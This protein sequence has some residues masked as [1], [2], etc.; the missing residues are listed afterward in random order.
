MP[1]I[2]TT[3]KQ[4]LKSSQDRPLNMVFI[5]NR[6]Q[7]FF[8]LSL[9]FFSSC[10]TLKNGEG[11]IQSGNFTDA[12]QIARAALEKDAQNWHALLLLTESLS[13]QKKYTD[14]EGHGNDLFEGTQKP[15]STIP[16][17]YYGRIFTVYGKI[18]WE[19]G[20]TLLA[21]KG[22]RQARKFDESLVPTEQYI[23]ALENGILYAESKFDFD[24]S[25]QIRNELHALQPNHPETTALKF[26]ASKDAEVSSLERSGRYE[27][28][29]KKYK[30]FLQETPDQ[31]QYQFALG[32][33]QAMMRDRTPQA[34]KTFD[35][36]IQLAQS[37]EKT[38]RTLKVAKQLETLNLPKISSKY[39]EHI[40][41]DNTQTKAQH[42]DLHLILARLYF[43]SNTPAPAHTHLQDYIKL[44]N[45]NATPSSKYY[46]AAAEIAVANNHTKIAVELL[47]QGAQEAPPNW[48]LSRTLADLLSRLSKDKDAEKI[49]QKFVDRASKENASE[50]VKH[51]LDVARWAATRRN[52]ELA[53]FFFEKAVIQKNF[54]SD[55]WLELSQIYAKLGFTSDLRR[56]L[57]SYFKRSSNTKT[58]KYRKVG[59]V[60]QAQ[61]MFAEAEKNYL[62]LL[63]Q[64][65]AN[66]EDVRTL[67]RLYR[68]WNKPKKINPV[69]KNWI[70]NR[71][72]NPADLI[73]IGDRFYQQNKYDLAKPY[74]LKAANAGE[75]EAWLRLA[76]IY[77]R[78]MKGQKMKHAIDSYIKGHS[79]QTQALNTA[80]LRYIRSPWQ[81]DAIPIYKK[82]I[83]LQPKTF[84]HYR[85]LAKIYIQNKE[86]E[87][88]NKIW[89]Q[90]IL[91][92]DDKALAMETIMRSN[93]PQYFGKSLLTLFESI[94][95]K[96]HNPNPK[97]YKILGD[98]HSQNSIAPSVR[99]SFQG[100]DNTTL[101]LHPNKAK[102]YYKKYLE[103]ASISKTSLR[104]FA[105]QMLHL[106]HW[107]LSVLAIEKLKIDESTSAPILFKYAS[108]LLQMG[109]A[110]DAEK[111]FL[112]YYEKRK[113][114][115]L[116]ASEIAELLYAN[117]R[118]N[119][120][121][122]Y[123]QKMM[124]SPNESVKKKAFIQLINIYI[125]T[126][127]SKNIAPLANQYIED[128]QNP[129][130]A[131]QILLSTL[132]SHGLWRLASDQLE[133]IIQEDNDEL[134]FQ[135]GTLYY[136]QGRDEDLRE[137]LDAYASSH[138][139]PGTAWL[140]V[141][142]FYAERGLFE[143]AE[144]A[145]T[146]ATQNLSNEN[147]PNAVNSLFEF[148]KFDIQRGDIESGQ[149]KY[150]E[151][152]KRLP[153]SQRD[154]SYIQEINQLKAQGYFME[155]QTLAKEAIPNADPA[156]LSFFFSG[157]SSAKFDNT[158]EKRKRELDSF[159]KSRPDL[160][161]SVNL[162]TNNLL[163]KKAINLIDIEIK[164]GNLQ[165]A[166][167]ILINNEHIFFSEGGLD[168][169]LQSARL[170]LN[171]NPKDSKLAFKIGRLLLEANRYREAISFLN[172]TQEPHFLLADAYLKTMDFENAF[173]TFQ[174]L[175]K[176]EQNPKDI[177]YKFATHIE[178]TPF[179]KDFTQA[180]KMLAE[181]P[182]FASFTMPILIRYLLDNH[183]LDEANAYVRK[184]WQ[185]NTD[186]YKVESPTLLNAVQR[187]IATSVEIQLRN[188][189]REYAIAGYPAE[190]KLLLNE[191]PEKLRHNPVMETLN[192]Q[193]VAFNAGPQGKTALL[194][195]AKEIENSDA[196]NS[197]RLSI[198][199]L[200]LA[201][202]RYETA[203]KIA[204]PLLENV[205]IQ[206]ST[207]S[208]K[209]LLS[210]YFA[211][212]KQNK[213][214]EIETRY[215][216]AHQDQRK[217]R[218]LA[219]EIYKSLSLDQRANTLAKIEANNEPTEVSNYNRLEIANLFQSEKENYDALIEKLWRSSRSPRNQLSIFAGR[220]GVQING[221]LYESLLQRLE[222]K[223]PGLENTIDRVRW[224]YRSAK[225]EHGRELLQAYLA[226]HSQDPGAHLLV[227]RL[228]YNM[229][230]PGEIVSWATKDIDVNRAP[231]QILILGGLAFQKV[232]KIKE[233]ILWL[234][235][236]IAKSPNPT[237]RA[238]FIANA[239][240]TQQAYTLGKKYNDYAIQKEPSIPNWYALDARLNL[241]LHDTKKAMESFQKVMDASAYIRSTR[242]QL[243][244]VALKT[245]QMKF[246]EKIAIPAFTTEY[247]HS[248]INAYIREFSKRGKAKEG[249][250][251]LEK[252][253]PFLLLKQGAPS[254]TLNN[255][256]ADLYENAGYP[257][258]AYNF[259]GDTLTKTRYGNWFALSGPANN[260]AYR[261]STANTNIQE[262]DALIRLCLSFFPH[263]NN[264]NS[265]LTSYIDTLGWIQYR[266]GH[267]D[268]AEKSIRNAMLKQERTT[269]A[270]R[271]EV[272]D[273]LRILLLKQGKYREA[274]KIELRLQMI[275]ARNGDLT[276]GVN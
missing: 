162:L 190:G 19:L 63:K 11:A 50:K 113:E 263:N 34:I 58:E 85:N 15:D 189:I 259:L 235:A 71:G 94:L 4:T 151:G 212:D 79:N 134:S 60:Y 161:N 51:Y 53:K 115:S 173:R 183:Q 145:F 110:K 101:F 182:E 59:A 112:Q 90:Y 273:H 196:G 170:I 3:P 39:Y 106:Q 56:S 187:T 69:F 160:G 118:F 239:L 13:G 136:A 274:S 92:S 178:K 7:I 36:Y 208:F 258:R 76:D 68:D 253:A 16:P 215:F 125:S 149:A 99:R 24:S 133:K 255:F 80:A 260:L 142:R 210:A 245:N 73:M 17:E 262:A 32:R 72:N 65:N 130:S 22:W 123:Y 107:D 108:A 153:I 47:N 191:F 167:N 229:G 155:A 29:I 256:I 147:D 185:T 188:A 168:R 46:I 87:N 37:S 97:I 205:K 44:S 38:T 213:I 55:A 240:A 132:Q 219:L 269:E 42:L 122:P 96:E 116:A 175:L 237:R 179:K 23:K 217:T 82:L 138:P 100:S 184:V 8:L 209:I 154:D 25:I 233:A 30:I 174:T 261:M 146:N 27:D 40:L 126:E 48:R 77:Q 14:A 140:R 193:L 18:Q 225:P 202:Q 206:T 84:S 181:D 227:F 141:A 61:R 33:L 62:Q 139:D 109:R 28:A 41:K 2:S 176:R 234:D 230:L 266:Q 54:P 169:F 131:R 91:S 152:R 111:M 86:S 129:V 57:N 70:K 249:L 265:D 275:E 250:D 247:N 242:F 157:A 26:Q 45:K 5:L 270:Q 127:R 271:H 199:L 105:N 88:A 165:L 207:L 201:S 143:N 211:L 164:T 156:N 252:Y 137:S 203:I 98:L 224:Y 121:E 104:D 171:K 226:D 64:K 75:N 186:I 232:G 243:F 214:N 192:L 148:A 264:P 228:L 89:E 200:A 103:L 43:K 221:E 257:K 114:S 150:A 31:H 6:I 135:L 35:T 158:G 223:S 81:D 66:F 172:R 9:L 163:Y 117:H 67:E 222:E 268:K 251:F 102:F 267:I 246:A 166:S 220:A 177:F 83:Q 195:K 276:R 128:A 216:N 236:A 194:E 244:R 159:S 93:M 20:R 198:A 12:E 248:W 1:L 10:I 204:E 120:A 144:N 78:Q 52:F 124:K 49:L 272:L 238:F 254:E 74:L 231:E 180:M 119:S 21:L 241:G 95:K 197:E 218:Q